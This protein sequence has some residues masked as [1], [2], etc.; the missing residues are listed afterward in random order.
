MKMS[1][2]HYSS[3]VGT[4][5][6][7]FFL[8]KS[9][10][11]S[12]G[13]VNY[14]KSSRMLRNT[15]FQIFRLQRTSPEFVCR[16][17]WFKIEFYPLVAGLNC[18]DILSLNPKNFVRKIFKGFPLGNGKKYFL[19]NSKLEK[20]IKLHLQVSINPF[21]HLVAAYQLAPPKTDL[22]SKNFIK[23]SSHED[24]DTL[25]LHV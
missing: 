19:H 6:V 14:T 9:P 15:D 25:N 24:K 3:I 10:N 21:H 12:N 1:V 22:A 20:K 5:R 11:H 13:C 4:F 2:M 7:P 16:Q 8:I 23:N 17:G 18:V